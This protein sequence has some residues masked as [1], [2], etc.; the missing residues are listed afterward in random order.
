MNVTEI[1]KEAWAAVQ[2]AGLP[3]ELQEVAFREAVRILGAQAAPDVKTP[4]V[5][6][7]APPPAGESAEIEAP[8]PVTEDQFFGKLSEATGV[9][10]QTLEEFFHLE[11]SEVRIIKAARYLGDSSK[12]Q[13]QTVGQ[14]LPVAYAEGLDQG[15]ISTGVVGQECRRLRCYDRNLNT[16][17]ASLEGISYVGP[18]RGRKLKVRASAVEPFK[19]IIKELTTPTASATG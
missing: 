14:L 18:A 5:K 17:L 1:L 19:R 13:M 12:A 16:Y 8:A 6:R 7:A 2:G 10:R 11:K 4:S 15:E 9:D 3:N